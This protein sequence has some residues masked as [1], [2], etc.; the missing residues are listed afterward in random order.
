M[1]K[2]SL[3]KTILLTLRKLTLENGG[4]RMDLISRP[5]ID[6]RNTPA[7]MAI[8]PSPK[9]DGAKTNKYVISNK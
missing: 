3:R 1:F 4:S 5:G 7:A 2:G 8:S 9:V 6:F